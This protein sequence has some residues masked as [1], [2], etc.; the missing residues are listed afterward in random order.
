MR[1]VNRNDAAGNSTLDTIN[2]SAFAIAS[3]QNRVS[4][5]SNQVFIYYFDAI[6][7]TF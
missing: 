3:S 2:A 5:P 1:R 6:N 4:Q 7:L